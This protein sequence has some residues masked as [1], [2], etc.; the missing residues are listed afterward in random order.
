[1]KR[2]SADYTRS[3]YW[4]EKCE[5]TCGWFCP[6]FVVTVKESVVTGYCFKTDSDI[7]L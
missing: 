5:Y 3:W 1:M 4:L 2:I 7:I 6:A